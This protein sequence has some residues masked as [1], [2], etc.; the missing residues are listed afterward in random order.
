MGGKRYGNGMGIDRL[1]IAPI[2]CCH[3]RETILPA[4]RRPLVN[5]VPVSAPLLS[6]KRLCL[7]LAYGFGRVPDWSSKP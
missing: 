5:T 6:L 1:L 3:V 7:C 2:D 4:G